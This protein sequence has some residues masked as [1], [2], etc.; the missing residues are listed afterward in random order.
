ML[1]QTGRKC[2]SGNRSTQVQRKKAPW[3]REIPTTDVIRHKCRSA[4]D[5]PI[6]AIITPK[7]ADKK[8]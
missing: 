2:D 3:V 1:S 6:W 5:V 4:S 7:A 8:Y